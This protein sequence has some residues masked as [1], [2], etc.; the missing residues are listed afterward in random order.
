MKTK[1]KNKKVKKAKTNESEKAVKLI[2]KTFGRALKKL[3]ER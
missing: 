2:G 3:S 1:S